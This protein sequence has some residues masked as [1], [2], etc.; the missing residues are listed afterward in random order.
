DLK[1]HGG[2]SEQ[3][4]HVCMD[5]SAAYAK[6]VGLALPQAQISYDRFHV[7][8]MAMDAM[9]QVR[10]TEMAQDAPAVRVALESAVDNDEHKTLKQ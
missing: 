6:G 2:D 7:V 3:V 1:A 4:K 9:D 5:M 10:R 8:A